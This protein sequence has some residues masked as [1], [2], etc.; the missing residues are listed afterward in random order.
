MKSWRSSACVSLLWLVACLVLCS[1]GCVLNFNERE[2]LRK[3]MAFLGLCKLLVA[4]CCLVVRF[5]FKW[6]HSESESEE[7]KEGEF[8][9]SA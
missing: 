4:G 8:L 5:M 9:Y 3:F 6:N 2:R 1:S 7:R